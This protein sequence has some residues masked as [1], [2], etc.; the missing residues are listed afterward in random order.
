M[1]MDVDL[2]IILQRASMLVLFLMLFLAGK[3]LKQLL[4]PYS[5]EQELT[6]EDNV[7]QATSLAGYY[8][9]LTALFSGAYLGPSAG[10][11][12]DLGTVAGYTL[13][14]LVLLNLS[15][16]I[17]DRYVLHAFSVAKAIRDQHNKAA[18]A[19]Q[20]ANYIASALVV[21]GALH[22]EGGGVFTALIF[23]G[24]GQIALVAFSRFYEW[25]TPYAIQQEIESDNLA[26][27]L[28][29]GGSMIAISLV[30][31]ASIKGD[32]IDWQTNLVWLALHLLSVFV[33]LVVVRFFSDRVI[34]AHDDLNTEIARDRNVGAGVLE[35]ALA[36][37]FASVL[38]FMVG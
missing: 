10:W 20:G 32:F 35:C 28:G 33:Y 37:S 38:F 11:L 12:M 36:I 16:A 1:S 17:N 8:I 5:I 7:A 30:V 18:G 3:Y 22:G 31:M 24:I 27:G 13:M 9:G 21:A 34:I 14:G 29:F 2:Q 26:A 19:V 15:R 6:K 25:L 23:Y 4:T